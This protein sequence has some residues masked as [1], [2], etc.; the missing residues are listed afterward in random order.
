MP[1]RSSKVHLGNSERVLDGCDG[2]DSNQ[3][4]LVDNKDWAGFHF[5]L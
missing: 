5:D 1:R 2:R 3:N 4:L